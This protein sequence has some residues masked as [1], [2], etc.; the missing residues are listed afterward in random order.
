MPSCDGVLGRFVFEGVV[1]G[2]F[3]RPLELPGVTTLALEDGVLGGTLEL[4]CSAPAQLSAL[5]HHTV[6][7]SEDGFEK[8]MQA[9]TLTLRWPVAAGASAIAVALEVRKG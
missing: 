4:L 8:I 9:I 2:G 6:S 7:Q 1:P 3:G 5:P